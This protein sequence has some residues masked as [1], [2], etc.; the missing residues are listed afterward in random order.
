MPNVEKLTSE[1][2]NMLGEG[3]N[4]IAYAEHPT[5]PPI[6]I[7]FPHNLPIKNR[8]IL[9]NKLLEKLKTN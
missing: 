3:Y 1:L 9:A 7:I 2:D 5:K 4:F 6:R 8:L